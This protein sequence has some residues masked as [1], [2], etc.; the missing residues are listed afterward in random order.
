MHY[1]LPDEV[2]T[3]TEWD[4]GGGLMGPD[5]ESPLVLTAVA[6]DDQAVTRPAS[7][8]GEDPRAGGDVEPRRC[9]QPGVA[10]SPDACLLT[11]KRLELLQ[12]AR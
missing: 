1:F 4:K 7:G 5:S 11:V 9:R 2:L 8:G 12:A 3:T 6:A 10:P